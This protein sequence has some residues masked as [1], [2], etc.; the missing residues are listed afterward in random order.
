VI[1][2]QFLYECRGDQ[3]ELPPLVQQLHVRLDIFIAVVVPTVALQDLAQEFPPIPVALLIDAANLV[4]V[5]LREA[6][7]RLA[8][9]IK[10]VQLLGVP[11]I[12]A[13]VVEVHEEMELLFLLSVLG[14]LLLI[15]EFPFLLSDFVEGVLSEHGS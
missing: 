15:L 8:E 6:R 5:C 12:D 2:V 11:V 14:V 13:L 9:N 1:F 7:G 10:K 3:P 4:D